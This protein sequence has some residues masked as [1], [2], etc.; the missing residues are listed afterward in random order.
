MKKHFFLLSRHPERFKDALP[1][2]KAED[3]ELKSAATISELVDL[4]R[5]TTCT[6]VILDLD[7]TAVD[8]RRL[9]QFS[10]QFPDLLL[11]AVSRRRFHPDLKEAMQRFIYACLR[12]PIDPEELSIVLGGIRDIESRA[13]GRTE[14]SANSQ[15][16]Q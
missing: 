3:L 12:Y 1:L 10:L 15:N 9:R 7:T 16:G 8:N 4:C 5:E 14:T 13:A 11:F 6:G 2:L